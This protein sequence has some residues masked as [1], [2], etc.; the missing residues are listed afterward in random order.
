MKNYD[1][2]VIPDYLDRQMFLD[3]AGG[4]TVQRFEEVAYPKVQEFEEIASGLLLASSRGL[5]QQDKIDHKKASD[6]QKFVFTQNLLRQTAL[7]SL[8]GRAPVTGVHAGLF[9]AGT[10]SADAAWSLLRDQHSLEEL[11]PHHPQHLQHAQ[12]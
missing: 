12:G 3:P 1:F 6:A 10:G 9:S 7:D 8:Q 2:S 11:Q 5:L 4:V